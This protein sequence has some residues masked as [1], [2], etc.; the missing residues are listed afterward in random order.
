MGPNEVSLD[1]VRSN[2]CVDQEI[3]AKFNLHAGIVKFS[4]HNEG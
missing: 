3:S 4:I 2:S 1:Q